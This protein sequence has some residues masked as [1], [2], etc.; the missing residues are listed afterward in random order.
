MKRQ[1]KNIKQAFAPSV[2]II[3]WKEK[4]DA[5]LHM[6]YWK[7]GGD[8]KKSCF[9]FRL[10]LRKS[11]TESVKIKHG[12]FFES[13]DDTLLSVRNKEM[14]NFFTHLIMASIDEC[15]KLVYP[16]QV[17]IPKDGIARIVE[18]GSFMNLN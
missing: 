12:W 17:T 5:T 16:S 18:R 3:E 9:K 10:I 13:P 4:A 6:D 2:E 8:N 14:F 15:N 11:Q 1:V 7:D